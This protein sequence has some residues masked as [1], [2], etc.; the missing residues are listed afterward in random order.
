M[1]EETK[2]LAAEDPNRTASGLPIDASQ[3]IDTT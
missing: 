3:G 1:A 2:P